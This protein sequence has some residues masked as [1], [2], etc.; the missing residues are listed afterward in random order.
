[1]D[2]SIIYVNYKTCELI[3]NSIRSVKERTE[4]ISYEMIVV[5]NASED[6]SLSIIKESYPE[7]VC[8]QSQENVGFGRA[9]NRGIAIAQ[10]ECILFLNP[11]TLLMNNAIAILYRFLQSS[12]QTG[13]CGGNLYDENK[14]PTHSFSRQVLSFRQELASIFYLPALC[15]K[16]PRSQFFNYTEKPLEVASIIGA[17]LMVKKKAL[18]KAG[19]FDTAFF[20]NMEETEL[21][22][23]IQQAG[24]KIM[25]VPA[26]KIIHL[27]GRAP[28]ISQSRLYY[29]YQGVLVFFHKKYGKSGART[30]YWCIQLKNNIRIIQ[31]TVL[32]YRKKII[33]WKIK[34]QTAK[35]AFQ[36]LKQSH[37]T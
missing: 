35:D 26:A 27:E 32:A 2:V 10:G 11:D 31:F 21:C 4:G 28:Y 3:L 7:V 25:S 22:Y 33:Y 16:A 29:L 8:I 18:E 1:M 9:N 19:V 37:R 24:F 15:L 12:G 14:R 23:R 5:D 36:A 17:D 30:I 34:K 13:A 20:L 6:N